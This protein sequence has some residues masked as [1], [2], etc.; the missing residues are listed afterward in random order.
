MSWIGR[1]MDKMGLC[2]QY[3]ADGLWEGEREGSAA[4]CKVKETFIQ[5]HK[6]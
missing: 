2:G 3:V 5:S 6:V 1:N 4:V